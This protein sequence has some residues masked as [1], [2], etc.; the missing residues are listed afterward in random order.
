M[1]HDFI[2]LIFDS[3]ENEVLFVKIGARFPDLCLEKSFGPKLP[4][5][6]F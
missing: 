5:A 6:S 4:Q 2:G 3:G 1:F